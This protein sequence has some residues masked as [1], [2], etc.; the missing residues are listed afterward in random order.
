MKQRNVS[1]TSWPFFKHS[2]PFHTQAY[3]NGMTGKGYIW[4][5][6]GW[7]APKWWEVDDSYVTCNLTEMRAAVESSNYIS[8]ETLQ[9]SPIPDVTVA[10][11]VS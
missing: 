5:F 6:V 9:L 3:R 4:M 11:I 7:Y 2:E 8:M 10:N 1:K